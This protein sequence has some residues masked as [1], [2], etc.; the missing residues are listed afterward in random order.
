MALVLP[1]HGNH[2]RTGL[3]WPEHVPDHWKLAQV[4]HWYS[5]TL[6]KMLQ[7]EPRTEADVLKPYMRA[8]NVRWGGADTSS[9]KKMWF[10]PSELRGLRINDGD[11]LVCEGGD[12][13]RSCVWAG[14]LD[15]CYFQ[16]SINRARPRQG[17]NPKYLY[18][19]LSA[20]K[21]VGIID[22]LCNRS[23]IPHFTA[24]KLQNTPLLVPPRLEEDQ[25]VTFLDHETARI[26]SLIAKQERLVTLL[27]EKWLGVLSQTIARGVDGRASLQESGL[28]WLGAVPAHWDVKRLKHISPRLGVGVVVNPSSYVSEEGVPFLYGANVTEYGFL[29]EGVRHISIRD[30]NSLPKSRLS[31]GDLVCVRVGY[32]GLTAVVP[33]ELE[34]SNCASM[35]VIKRG[36]FNSKWLAYAMNSSIGKRQVAMVQY[37]AAQEQFNIGDAVNFVFP[38][39]PRS[40]QDEMSDHL[41]SLWAEFENLARATHRMIDLL[42]ERRSSLISAAVTGQIDVRGW[43]S[44]PAA[45]QEMALGD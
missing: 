9:V 19:W 5:V 23:T 38:V 31:A 37:G 42:K 33:P 24:D 29:L 14:E 40:E 10:G 21:S 12:V 13:G 41:D 16:N 3:V 2:K 34:G 22:V 15:E 25:I 43:E 30:S 7:P 8:A 18:Y 45:D 44:G 35:M 17:R 4:K 26:D 28:D 11:V 1:R 20:L 39:P 6:G 27:Q 36:D 32:P